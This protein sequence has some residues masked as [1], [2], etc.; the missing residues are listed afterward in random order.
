M[1]V[2]AD[3]GWEPAGV[4]YGADEHHQRVGGNGLRAGGSGFF[5][6]QGL[7]FSGACGSGDL[8]AGARPRPAEP[9]GYAATVD[10]S[11]ESDPILMALF[12]QPPDDRHVHLAY[13]NVG[14]QIYDV[15]DPRDPYITGYFIA[16]DPKQRRGPIPSKLVQQAQDVVVDRR[17]VI[18]M[19]EGNTGIYILRHQTSRGKART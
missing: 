18:Y 8:G 15:S 3:V 6:G 7:Q 12:P 19:S 9:A 11:D 2:P 1:L 16:D 4:R 17:G 14:L 13:F 10:I 5:Q